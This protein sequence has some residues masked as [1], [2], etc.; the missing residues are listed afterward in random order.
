ML[1]S[2][3]FNWTV[4]FFHLV[5]V[6]SQCYHWQSVLFLPDKSHTNFIVFAKRWNR[7]W[8]QR[9]IVAEFGRDHQGKLKVSRPRNLGHP[10]FLISKDS[11]GTGKPTRNCLKD[12]KLFSFDQGIAKTS[13]RI[14]ENTPSIKQRWRIISSA[15]KYLIDEVLL[16]DAISRYILPTK[17]DFVLRESFVIRWSIVAVALSSEGRKLFQI[18]LS[19][20][21][22][23]IPELK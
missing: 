23:Q 12:N 14:E 9:T 2:S 4:F 15:L 6:G 21:F 19:G 8:I 10:E 22:S 20:H 18:N 3:I 13:L 1:I 7:L 16:F 5:W 11:G 17:Q